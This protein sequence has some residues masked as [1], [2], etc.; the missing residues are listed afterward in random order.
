MGFNSGFKGLTYCVVPRMRSIKEKDT[1]T[2]RKFSNS[3][4]YFVFWILLRVTRWRYHD[5]LQE[6]SAFP[7]DPTTKPIFPETSILNIE[8]ADNSYHEILST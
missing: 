1:Y 5:I 2:E 8:F 6:R 4:D 7:F 3:Y